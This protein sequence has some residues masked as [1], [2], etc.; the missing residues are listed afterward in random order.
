MAQMLVYEGSIA[1]VLVGLPEVFVQMLIF[2]V[3]LFAWERRA[4]RH[5]QPQT[6]EGGPRYPS[7]A[8]Q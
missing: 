3:A 4:H 2:A 7:A 6:V 5:E 1:P 8:E